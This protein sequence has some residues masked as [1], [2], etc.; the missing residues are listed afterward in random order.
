ML[1]RLLEQ[2][3]RQSMVDN[4]EHHH[5]TAV[6]QYRGVRCQ[7]QHFVLCL[8]VLDRLDHQRCIERPRRFIRCRA[9]AARPAAS[10]RR[11]NGAA[12]RRFLVIAAGGL[13]QER[14][15]DDQL[16]RC[17]VALVG[18]MSVL[19]EEGD[20]PSMELGLGDHEG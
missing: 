2:R 10:W 12:A 11:G 17:K 20:Q 15:G 4:R 1:E 9:T 13:A 3:N 18:R 14:P 7:M 16:Q 8:P 6:P 19:T 5:A